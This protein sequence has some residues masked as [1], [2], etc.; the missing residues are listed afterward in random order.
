[1]KETKDYVNNEVEH[2][3]ATVNTLTLR[4]MKYF[5]TNT[6]LI[7]GKTLKLRLQ[8]QQNKTLT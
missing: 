1:M 7:E 3:N 8:N 4:R 2:I 6:K 5:E